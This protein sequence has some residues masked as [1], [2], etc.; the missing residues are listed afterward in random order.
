MRKKDVS[1]LFKPDFESYVPK[2]A[3]N[4]KTVRIARGLEVEENAEM[5]I[6]N[7]V[8]IGS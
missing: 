7:L 2:L 8:S 3:E 1:S 6:D 5:I 4:Q